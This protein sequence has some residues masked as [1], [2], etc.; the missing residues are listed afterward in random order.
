MNLI[1]F[2]SGA[3]TLLAGII[4]G[5]I[6]RPK[7]TAAPAQ[8]PKTRCGSCGHGLGMHSKGS[9][10]CHGSSERDAYSA[11]YWMG[12]ESIPCGCQHYDGPQ[13]LPEYFAPEIS[14]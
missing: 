7:R 5:R 1:D 11:G 9:G 14:A 4:L 2:L 3:G 13:P 12:K 8:P 6:T 10:E